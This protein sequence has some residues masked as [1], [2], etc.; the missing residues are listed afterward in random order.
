MELKAYTHKVVAIRGGTVFSG[1]LDACEQYMLNAGGEAL[2]WQILP[3]NERVARWG[4][5]EIATI[6]PGSLLWR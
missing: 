4:S 1:P 3:L 2:G 6:R 5:D